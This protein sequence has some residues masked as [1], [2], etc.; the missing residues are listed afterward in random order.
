MRSGECTL[1]IYVGLRE[2]T[3]IRLNLQDFDVGCLLNYLRREFS[4]LIDQSRKE[5]TTSLDILTNGRK[6]RSNRQGED[7]GKK[8]QVTGQKRKL[9]RSP[10]ETTNPPA[11]AIN[12]SPLA[13]LPSSFSLWVS[14][15]CSLKLTPAQKVATQ[16]PTMQPEPVIS[17]NSGCPFDSF[18]TVYPSET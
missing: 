6:L 14:S 18:R 15:A 5:S 1:N 11:A 4:K 16:V 9:I 12:I 8:N 10:E 7:T 17:P 3:N 13:N 2:L